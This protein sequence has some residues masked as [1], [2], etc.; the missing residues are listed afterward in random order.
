MCTDQTPSGFHPIVPSTHREPDPEPADRIGLDPVDAIRLTTLVD[1]QTD[2][3]LPD[4]GPVKRTGLLAVATA[5]RL[6]A[7]VLD[8]GDT[9]DIPSRRTGSRCWSPSPAPGVTTGCS[10]GL[11]AHGSAVASPTRNATLGKPCAAANR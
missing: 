8:T 5:P 6:P 4:Q 11:R 9:F 7:S 1:N 10:T 2:L 3:L